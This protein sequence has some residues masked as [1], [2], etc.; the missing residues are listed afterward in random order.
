MRQ[1]KIVCTIGP[2]SESPTVIAKLVQRGMNIARLNLSH[3][4]LEEHR[5]RIRNIRAINAEQN[6]MVSILLDIQ[7]P[8][9]RTG[10]LP[11][12]TREVEEGELLAFSPDP[13]RSRTA[14]FILLMT[15]C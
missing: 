2:A 10:L 5:N 11:E 1:T 3:G 13:K 9:I 6:K 8:K 12:G 7:G 4:T 14:A 15:T